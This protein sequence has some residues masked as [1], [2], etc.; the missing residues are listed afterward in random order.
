MGA[1]SACLKHGQQ[2]KV[3][4]AEEGRVV[5]VEEAQADLGEPSMKL[6]EF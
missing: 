2:T 4:A 3:A 5:V 1:C 6:L